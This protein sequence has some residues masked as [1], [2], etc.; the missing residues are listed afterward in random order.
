METFSQNQSFNRSLSEVQK[1]KNQR[2]KLNQI[3]VIMNILK[4]V[5]KLLYYQS[6]SQNVDLK[7]FQV[8]KRLS[9]A[10]LRLLSVWLFS[11][12]P[13]AL[14]FLANISGYSS[15]VTHHADMLPGNLEEKSQNL[16]L[17]F[18][19]SNFCQ[20]FLCCQP[21]DLWTHVSFLISSYLEDI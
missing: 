5:Y 16:Q 9:R 19:F 13:Y 14:V 1:M 4:L 21:L 8:E 12:T 17:L 11:W 10:S 7:N 3:S 20:T 15:L 6:F 2:T 18:H